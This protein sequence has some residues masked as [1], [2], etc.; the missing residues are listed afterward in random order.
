M[1][2]VVMFNVWCPVKGYALV[3]Y[4]IAHIRLGWKLLSNLDT[5]ENTYHR[6]AYLTYFAV[7]QVRK[8]KVL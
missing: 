8:K 4:S 2:S 5:I 3:G 7:V 6:L 1:L